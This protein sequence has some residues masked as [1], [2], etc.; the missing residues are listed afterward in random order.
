MRGKRAHLIR[1][2]LSGIGCPASERAGQRVMDS[3]TRFLSKVLRLEVNPRKSK[4]AK[5]NQCR[6]LGFAFR[7]KK[8]VW[9]EKSL[10]L[11]GR[12]AYFAQMS[13]AGGRIAQAGRLGTASRDDGAQ[14]Q[15]LLAPLPHSGNAVGSEQ[16]MA[17]IAGLGLDA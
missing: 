4:V 16:R 6:F 12:L 13:P 9:S 5:L 10:Y 2:D 14:P 3:L 15:E 11:R 8:I 17:E 1:E 7:R